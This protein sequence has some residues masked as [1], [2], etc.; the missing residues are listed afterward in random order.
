M[1]IGQVIGRVTMSH[2]LDAFKGGRFLLVIPATREYLLSGTPEPLPKGNSLVVFDELGAS[3][4]DRIA[5][6]EGGEAA[7]SFHKDTPVDAYNCM[8]LDHII[9]Q[10]PNA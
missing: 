6:S 9:Y 4:G 7:A 1:K 10:P 3:A 5:F 8:I 2:K